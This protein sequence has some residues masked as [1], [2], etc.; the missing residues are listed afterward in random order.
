MIFSKPDTS[1]ASLFSNDKLEEFLDSLPWTYEESYRS[2]II[3]LSDV[4]NVSIIMETL[5]QGIDK[6][7]IDEKKY[8]IRGHLIFRT[9]PNL[10][11]PKREER[12]SFTITEIKNE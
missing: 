12:K 10:P 1:I 9:H 3:K 5:L 6:M 7:Q 8:F 11:R 2:E 4:G